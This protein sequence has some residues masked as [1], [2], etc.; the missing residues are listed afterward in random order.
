MASCSTF[1]ATL[2]ISL[3]AQVAT[4][5]VKVLICFFNFMIDLVKICHRFDPCEM[6]VGKSRS[7]VSCR[8]WYLKHQSLSLTLSHSLSLCA[9]ARARALDLKCHSYTHSP[10]PPI[11]PRPALLR[12][13]PPLLPKHSTSPL[14]LPSVPTGPPPS[15]S[16]FS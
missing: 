2:S 1:E 14:L 4:S 15:L 13:T 8:Y 7:R 3:I 10:P 11:P 5:S 16:A 6:H 12:L 9:R